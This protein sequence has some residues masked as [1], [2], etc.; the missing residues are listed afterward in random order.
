MKLKE[1][2]AAARGRWGPL[3]IYQK[4]EDVVVNILTALIALVI[5]FALW[6]LI[7]N[8]VFGN[9]WNDALD[10]ADHAVFQ[11]VFGAIFTVLIA[12]EFEKSLLVLAARHDSIVQVRTVVLI[13][14]LAVLR[15]LIVLDFA[16]TDALHL[17][18]LSAAILALGGVY[19]LVREQ[20]D[21]R[22]PPGPT[23]STEA[24]SETE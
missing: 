5:V 13:A 9:L 19:W 22:E 20:D 12:L 1:E 4:F 6:N 23:P 2:M 17:F 16:V 7:R 18:A 8:I 3:T 15:K 21:R 10:P 24:S 11:T 14:L